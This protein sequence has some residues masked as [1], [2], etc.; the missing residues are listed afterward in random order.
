M[1][2]SAAITNEIYKLWWLIPLLL[3]VTVFKTPWFKGLA[4]EALVKLAARLR[5]PADTYHPI[6][7][8]TLPTPDGTTQID[9]I[10]VS[11]FGIFVVETKNM[12]G[13][14]FGAEN[15]A[16]WT[17]K[18]FKQTFR[19]QN[20]LRQ[21]YKHLKALE[22]ALDVPPE[23]MHSVVVFAGDSTF[24]SPMP[25]NVTKGGGYIT[26]IKSF[27]ETVLTES[28][29]QNVLGQIRAGRLEPTRK[30]H[31]QHVQQ[32][33][34][35]SDP[36]AERKCPKCGSPMVLRT[37]KQGANAGRQFWGCSTFPKCKVM[38]NVTEL[39]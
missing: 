7:N 1:D 8:V 15:Q 14:I 22:A 11:R 19:F 38:Q 21:N 26:Y 4:G 2:Y 5:L 10:F 25:A 32:L 36:T 35:R 16:E 18:I 29:V 17:Q 27:R 37:A 31:R 30:T 20:P 28:E 24:K 12:K 6:H 33:K 34:S 3:V 9:H 23:V 39:H 13:W